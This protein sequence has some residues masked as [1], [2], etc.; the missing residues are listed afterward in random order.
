M[1]KSELIES[2]N[3]IT[4]NAF[5]EIINEFRE[6]EIRRFYIIANEA[7]REGMRYAQERFVEKLQEAFGVNQITTQAEDEPCTSTRG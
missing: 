1:D 5:N 4:N 2:L 6:E 3:K 7:Y